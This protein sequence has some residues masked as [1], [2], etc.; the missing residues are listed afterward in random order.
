[1]AVL[2]NISFQYRYICGISMY[3]NYIEINP[4]YSMIV[5]IL[6]LTTTKLAATKLPTEKHFLIVWIYCWLKSYERFYNHSFNVNRSKLYTWRSVFIFHALLNIPLLPTR[7]YWTDA[8]STFS[9]QNFYLSE[10]L[11]GISSYGSHDGKL[12][13][14]YW[15]VTFNLPQRP[16]FVYLRSCLKCWNHSGNDSC[17]RAT[18]GKSSLLEVNGWQ[19]GWVI[20]WSNI[21][22]LLTSL[23]FEHF[24]F[25]WSIFWKWEE[26]HYFL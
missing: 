14:V 5:E 8:Q 24:P 16:L 4:K 7:K 23:K 10:T 1:M 20:W 9:S 19:C 11:A 17:N 12:F 2:S 13:S 3:L 25:K 15:W 26:S 22:W 18:F 6:I 21:A